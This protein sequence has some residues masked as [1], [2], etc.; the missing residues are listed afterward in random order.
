MNVARLNLC[1]GTR[2]SHS[3]S[4]TNLREILAAHPEQ[5][6]ALLLDVSGEVR[7]GRLKN[8]K[9]LLSAG[10]EVSIC[11]DPLVEGDHKTISLDYTNIHDVVKYAPPSLRFS[12]TIH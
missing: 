8:K 2:D 7:V 4:I 3:Q 11:C 5:H 12:R 10:T 6:C 1:H 9:Q